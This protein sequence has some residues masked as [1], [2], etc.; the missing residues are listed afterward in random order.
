[1]PD[2]GESVRLHFADGR[3]AGTYERGSDRLEIRVR[4]MSFKATMVPVDLS[5]LD[6]VVEL[7]E[8]VVL[9]EQDEMRIGSV[10]LPRSLPALETLIVGSRIANVEVLGEMSRLRRVRTAWA[11]PK[12]SLERLVDL[13]ELRMGVSRRLAVD[14][15]WFPSL[16]RLRR[17]DLESV[18]R[19]PIEF[20]LELPSLRDLS[21]IALQ[22]SPGRVVGRL[23]QLE[24][25]GV[26]LPSNS[27]R[28]LESLGRL[29]TLRMRVPASSVVALEAL[30]LQ[31]LQLF[32]S[33]LRDEAAAS[34]GRLE[35]L[36]MLVLWSRRVATLEWLKGLSLLEDLDLNDCHSI[37]RL[38]PISALSRLRRLSLRNLGGV[39]SFRP[40]MGLAGLETVLLHG[41]RPDDPREAAELVEALPVARV[42]VSVDPPSADDPIERIVDGTRIK[43]SLRA[44][45][46]YLVSADLAGLVA[47]DDQDAAAELVR[48]RLE[49]VVEATFESEGSETTITVA[50]F[51]EARRVSDLI[52]ELARERS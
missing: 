27:V 51:P 26:E 5:P 23:T 30:P 24:A 49:P 10:V 44:G 43:I 41:T 15:D 48:D 6:G 31:E 8:I 9:A 2:A 7:R 47:D 39:R 29:R 13:E 35:E 22:R 4:S 17:L 12:E 40:L 1:M 25:L 28:F 16:P 46:G 11:I 20:L 34:I 37:E 50:T 33:G 45:G 42:E 36:R 18:G 21:M 52:A 19:A 38:D 3:P 14:A 32:A